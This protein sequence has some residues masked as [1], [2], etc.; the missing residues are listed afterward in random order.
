MFLPNIYITDSV[1][2]IN[3]EIHVK[4]LISNSWIIALD[5]QILYFIF[6]KNNKQNVRA[7]S[8]CDI[9]CVHSNDNDTDAQLELTTTECE[10]ML[11]YYFMNL[12][13]RLEAKNRFLFVLLVINSL[14]A[15]H[16]C[17]LTST[18]TST[19]LICTAS[20]HFSRR[21]CCCC[22]KWRER[23]GKKLKCL[24]VFAFVFTFVS[25]PYFVS[26]MLRS[27]AD[28]LDKD[29]ERKLASKRRRRRQPKM[30]MS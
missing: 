19:W 7:I 14:V 3:T 27:T 20:K 9:Q 16:V 13:T 10:L 25:C 21:C 26:Q 18:S 28:S 23:G 6:Q 17:A 1:T 11:D 15:M 30:Q 4:R 29:E 24:F 12:R 5:R 8:R 22:S 2:P